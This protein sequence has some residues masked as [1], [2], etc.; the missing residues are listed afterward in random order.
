MDYGGGGRVNVG[1]VNLGKKGCGGGTGK[2]GR[3][4]N[5]RL[6]SNV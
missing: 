6:G 3:E 2:S 1:G 5:L 4:G